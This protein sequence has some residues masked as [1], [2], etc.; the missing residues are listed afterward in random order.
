MTATIDQAASCF[1]KG[2]SK[3]AAQSHLTKIYLYINHLHKCTSLTFNN[4]LKSH[5]C[6]LFETFGYENIDVPTRVNWIICMYTFRLQ[7]F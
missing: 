6:L 5:V 3:S 1:S 2:D 7:V 4:K